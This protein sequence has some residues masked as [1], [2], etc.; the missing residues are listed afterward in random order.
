MAFSIRWKF[1]RLYF[2]VIKVHARLG[3]GG[4]WEGILYMKGVGMLFVS[5][6]GVNFGFWSCLECSGQN[7]IIF[8]RKGLS[9]RVA[10]KE[11]LRGCLSKIRPLNFAWKTILPETLASERLYRD[12]NWNRFAFI[13][14]NFR[15]ARGAPSILSHHGHFAG[16]ENW[17]FDI[18]CGA[19]K[20]LICTIYQWILYLSIGKHL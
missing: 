8:S 2:F 4:G 20:C 3:G 14:N 13:H 5:L 10:L 6:R 17:K 16:L 19:V 7:T 1:F 15:A 18:L 9:F 12:H 11:M